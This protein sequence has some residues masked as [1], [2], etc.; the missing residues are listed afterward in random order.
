MPGMPGGS[1]AYGSGGMGGR[2]FDSNAKRVEKN[3]EYI[4]IEDLDKAMEKGK[5]PAMT[6]IPLRGV[7]LHAEIP[8]KKQI[9][10]IKRA[11]RLSSDAEAKMWG[12]LYDGYEVQRRVT[13]TIDGQLED[14]GWNNYNFEDVY[15][16]KINSKKLGD[17]IEEG[18]LSYF[19]RYEM[20][21]ALPLPQLVS[22]LGDYP[23]IR[24][25]NIVSTISKLKDA[26]AKKVQPSDT[27]ERL[28]SHKTRNELYQLQ[29]ANDTG[30]A[31]LYGPAA[32][33]LMGEGPKMPKPP[34]PSAPSG[35]TG[36]RPGMTDP[37]N[38]N[39]STPVEID[40]LLLRFVD[41]DVEPGKTYQY[42]IRLRMLNPNYKRTSEVANPV[43]A[44]KE[45]LESPWTEFPDM[46]TIPPERYLYAA[47][48]AT[49]RK[50]IE[51]SYSN[52]NK[53]EQEIRER[54]QV[55][56]NQAVVEIC[57]WMMEVRT[58]SGKREP[59][60]AWVVADIPVG[61]GEFI[62][63]KQ[64]VKLPL[65]SSETK[66]Y[67]LREITTTAGKTSGHKE[68]NQ[69]RG[70]MVDFTASTQ[71]ILVDFEGG[72][73]QTRRDNRPVMTE[74]VATELLVLSPNGKLTVKKSIVDD[75]DA[76]RKKITG[77]WTK[78]I[79]EV[80]KRIK[81]GGAEENNGLA[82]KPGGP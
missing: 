62:G 25:K 64:Y 38:T 80:E 56:D 6:V 82:P 63:R 36:Y 21:L 28:R 46:I 41:V 59:V 67:V 14:S 54:L 10:E 26:G 51:D 17:A 76:F 33:G 16:E 3:L 9:E 39:A 66:S 29:S 58:D 73:V 7:I 49:Y 48:V 5:V 61:R 13:R 45:V 23:D 68:L 31:G 32:G 18:Y 53:A 20:L 40:Q 70:W 11:L 77:M 27:L 79:A 22:E 74:D 34:G 15:Q 12:P 30:A 1:G 44:N 55:K 37:T 8:Y 65:W 75:N 4:P 52:K 71:D 72:K 42:R 2:G 50:A 60:G 69:P 24:L 19:L 35:P 47:D 57:E 81:S 78:W 43:Y